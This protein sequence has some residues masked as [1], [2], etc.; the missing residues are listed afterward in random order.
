MMTTRPIPALED[1]QNLRYHPLSELVDFGVGI[2]LN[3]VADHMRTNGYDAD[4]PIVVIWDER[5]QAYLI[6]DGRHRLQ[7][8]ILAGVTPVF[9]VFDGD[10]RA[11]LEFVRKKLLRQ[12]LDASQKGIIAARYSNL[13]KGQIPSSGGISI[14]QAAELLNVGENTV[15]RGKTVLAHGTA[16]LQAA[17]MD[18]TISVTDA[19]IVAKEAPDIQNA[20][21]EAVRAGESRTASAATRPTTKEP[22]KPDPLKLP[23]LCKKCR[24]KGFAFCA[25]CVAKASAHRAVVDAAEALLPPPKPEGLDFEG[26]QFERIREHAD[27]I[28]AD[29]EGIS[30]AFGDSWQRRDIRG[31][32]DKIKE[33]SVSWQRQVAAQLR[34]RGRSAIGPGSERR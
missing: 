13:S 23:K 26:A 33:S 3:A 27:G 6:L 29:A 1:W 22:T 15:E 16:E 2:D 18:R 24:S 28:E 5:S 7:A 30:E 17:V 10:E 31:H 4:E 11:A 32:C 12:H 20:A 19:A 9:R 21:V 14:S 8:A 34:P 25:K